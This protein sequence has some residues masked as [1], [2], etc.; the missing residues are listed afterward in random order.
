MGGAGALA[1]PKSALAGW[2]KG[3]SWGK[4]LSKDRG[5]LIPKW[6]RSHTYQREMELEE[7][8][9]GT[10]TKGKSGKHKADLFMEKHLPKFIR[11]AG[12]KEKSNVCYNH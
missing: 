10:E 4:T 2:K 9:S 1:G 8:L 12:K 3:S 6:K 5:T 11:G 7:G